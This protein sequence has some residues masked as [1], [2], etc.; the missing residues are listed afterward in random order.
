MRRRAE[1]VNLPATSRGY[2]LTHVPRGT[3]D[4]EP[5]YRPRGTDVLFA[6]AEAAEDLAQA[7]RRRATSPVIR[8]RRTLRQA[9]SSSAI[10]FKEPA[11]RRRGLR[12]GACGRPS[13]ATGGARGPV[14][15]PSPWGVQ[16]GHVQQPRAHALRSRRP[17]WPKPGCSVSPLTVDRDLPRAPARSILLTTRARGSACRQS[18]AKDASSVRL[19]WASP[20]R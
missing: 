5:V 9:D 15:S 14:K 6:D 7:G 11:I 8:P 19:A 20:F 10:Q 3:I 18:R 17:S 12:P 1:T 13:G 4:A 16:P 2:V